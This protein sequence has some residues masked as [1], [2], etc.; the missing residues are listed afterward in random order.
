MKIKKIYLLNVFFDVLNFF[1]Y[2]YVLKF[3]DLVLN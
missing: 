1:D 2:V 3:Y